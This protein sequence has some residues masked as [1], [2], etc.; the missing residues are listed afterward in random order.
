VPIFV[1]PRTYASSSWADG[2]SY[3]PGKTSTSYNGG[4]GCPD[5]NQLLPCGRSGS[6]IQLRRCSSPPEV[7]GQRNDGVFRHPAEILQAA[8]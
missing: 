4:N 7:G 1:E 8:M 2:I 6:E 5:R 3:A